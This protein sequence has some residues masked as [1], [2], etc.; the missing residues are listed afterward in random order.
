MLYYLDTVEIRSGLDNTIGDST[1]LA[2]M[3]HAAVCGA[4]AASGFVS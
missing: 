4:G 2:S 3:C 1:G